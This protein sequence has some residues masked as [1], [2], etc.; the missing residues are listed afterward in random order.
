LSTAGNLLLDKFTKAFT[1]AP[2]VLWEVLGFILLTV[3]EFTAI[4]TVDLSERKI[5]VQYAKQVKGR[6]MY[7]GQ[8]SVIPMKISG[9]GVMP[10]IFAFAI[11]SFPSMLAS[12]F[13]PG[14]PFEGWLNEWFSGNSPFW[15]G[16]LIYMVVLC[17][18]IFG[19]AFFLAS[20]ATYGSS[21]FLKSIPK[22]EASGNRFPAHKNQVPPAKCAGGTNFLIYSQPGFSDSALGWR[23]SSFFVASAADAPS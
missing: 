19:F 4:V 6:K 14:S 9:S 7:G 10:L 5:P 8:S 3:V 11:I 12:M 1:G 15:Y 23:T 22:V 17:L 16:Q 13:W 20:L 2:E 21:R 18:L